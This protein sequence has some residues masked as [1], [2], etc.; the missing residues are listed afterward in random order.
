MAMLLDN[1]EGE[2]EDSELWQEQCLCEQ[3]CKAIQ[4]ADLELLP[5]AQEP[6][7]SADHKAQNDQ[8]MLCMMG[9]IIFSLMAVAIY[10]PLIIITFNWHSKSS[11]KCFDSLEELQ[12]S[13]DCFITTQIHK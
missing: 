7:I 1:K 12:E 9:L 11:F 10:I 2:Q 5:T 4:I 6:V 8:H 3:E 13:V